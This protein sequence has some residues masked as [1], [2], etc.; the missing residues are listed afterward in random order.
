MPDA[1]SKTIPIWC[2]VLNA[3]SYQKYGIPEEGKEGFRLETPRWMIPPT[4]HD[5]IEARIEE[6]VQ[7]LLESDLE[8]PRL[9]KPL[10]PVFITPQT[11]LSTISK[12]LTE[13]YTPI[14][15]VSASRFVSDSAK[16]SS[17]D[18]Q[19]EDGRR[20][21]F[22]YVQ[23]AGDD[24]ENWARGLTPDVFWKHR[25]ELLA[26]E[27]DELEGFVDKIVAD[28]ASKGAGSTHWLRLVRRHP[29]ASPS[30]GAGCGGNDVEIGRT[31]V[32]IGIRAAD[33][34]FSHVE[35]QGYDLIIH[36]ISLP[37]PLPSTDLPDS[38][39]SL[40][41]S[42]AQPVPAQIYPIHMSAN[43]KGLLAIRATFPSAIEVA[44]RTLTKPS[45]PTEG[46]QAK[47]VSLLSRRQGSLW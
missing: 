7:A 29:D 36:F 46:Q 33:H 17:P 39:S 37:P 13:E 45:T 21:A 16:L 35:K 26:C 18:E 15:L 44:H 1:L 8:V 40:T 25:A 23:G 12:A 31:G 11:D 10:R 38:L 32:Y 19:H 30:S 27:K 9:E 42:D 41:L 2:A 43:K 3:A 5:Q 47:S 4:E 20:K 28:E 34:I 14:V 6:F 24:H 22:V